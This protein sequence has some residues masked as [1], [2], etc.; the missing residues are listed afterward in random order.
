[1]LRKNRWYLRAAGSILDL[2]PDTDYLKLV[3]KKSDSENMSGDIHAIGNDIRVSAQD[4]A[5]D[6]GITRTRNA[7]TRTRC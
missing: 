7:V 3:G 6:K 1:M 4:Y 2:A 5:R